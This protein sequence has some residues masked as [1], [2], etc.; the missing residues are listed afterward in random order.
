MGVEQ[1]GSGAFTKPARLGL[2]VIGYPEKLVYA[3]YCRAESLCL[4]S[5][6]ECLC[7]DAAE[8]ST[9]ASR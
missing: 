6:K 9:M 2:A 8:P 4:P 7:L 3:R 1:P 5:T